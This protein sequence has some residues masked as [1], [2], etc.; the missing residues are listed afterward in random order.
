MQLNHTLSHLRLVSFLSFSLGL[1]VD[2]ICT[3]SAQ[4]AP[5][6]F[7]VRTLD[8]I[9]SQVERH[10]K[11]LNVPLVVGIQDLDVRDWQMRI[12]CDRFRDSLELCLR[13]GPAGYAGH[14]LARLKMR[15]CKLPEISAMRYR[16]HRD[17]R[18]FD[19]PREFGKIY[20]ESFARNLFQLAHWVNTIG[21][22]SH[23]DFLKVLLPEFDEF[24]FAAEATALVK[25]G[26]KV[27][28]LAF[29]VKTKGGETQFSQRVVLFED[30]S[31]STTD[32]KHIFLSS[33]KWLEAIRWFSDCFHEGGPFPSG[34]G[35]VGTL[36]N[37]YDDTG[38]PYQFRETSQAKS[39]AP[40]PAA[41]P[42]PS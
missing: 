12:M 11:T 22:A 15:C 23:A 17:D 24:G 35:F 31:D 5:H 21:D 33:G 38:T 37:V 20:F 19:A 7:H 39:P 3:F 27:G 42:H 9:S 6:W 14:V 36:L 8:S 30:D 25:L 32:L 16:S 28:S 1:P 41:S 18:G 10:S 29:K 40:P 4:L 13:S 34:E 2:L 26:G